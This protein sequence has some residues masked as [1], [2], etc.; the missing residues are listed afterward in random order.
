MLVAIFRAPFTWRA[1]SLEDTAERGDVN[2]NL[3]LIF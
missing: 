1:F 3:L 2:Y